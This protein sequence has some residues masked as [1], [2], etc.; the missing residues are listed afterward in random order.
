MSRHFQVDHQPQLNFVMSSTYIET[1]NETDALNFIVKLIK[2]KKLHHPLFDVWKYSSTSDNCK[3]CEEIKTCNQ[4]HNEILKQKV[5]SHIIE[6]CCCSD[7]KLKSLL[8]T[9]NR[10]SSS[11]G[12]VSE[13]RENPANK[14]DLKDFYSQYD[15]ETDNTRYFCHVCVVYGTVA[16][17]KAYTDGG[18]WMNKG[19]SFKSRKSRIKLYM[20]RHIKSRNHIAAL[21]RRQTKIGCTNQPDD[22]VENER[23]PAARNLCMA[24]QYVVDSK[25]SND[26]ITNLA[27]FIKLISPEDQMNPLGNINDPTENFENLILANYDAG[28]IQIRTK[29]NTVN[30]LTRQSRR[31]TISI[32]QVTV[33]Y[34]ITR[35]I[36]VVNYIDDN[37]N[38]TRTC[39]SAG[40]IFSDS[41]EDVLKHISKCCSDFFSLKSIVAICTD[42]A[43]N[44]TGKNMDEVYE[45]MKSDLNYDKRILHLPNL[46]QSIE[47]LLKNNI[48]SC[49]KESLSKIDIIRQIL[50]GKNILSQ[51]LSEFSN[52]HNDLNFFPFEE[53]DEGKYFEYIYHSI[54][55][56]LRNLQ[57]LHIYLPKILNNDRL[58]HLHD[59]AKTV[60]EIVSSYTFISD[61]LFTNAILKE[62]SELDKITSSQELDVKKFIEIKCQLKN[63]LSLLQNKFPLVC[64][65]FFETCK[66]EYVY[67]HDERQYI[68]LVELKNPSHNVN[69]LK[70]EYKKWIQKLLF[71]IDSDISL[72][73]PIEIFDKFFDINDPDDKVY[74][75][76]NIFET[77]NLKFFPCIYGCSGL[78]ICE[79]VMKEINLFINYVNE[80]S[81]ACLLDGK[82]CPKMFIKSV[83]PYRTH[84]LKIRNIYRMVEF[85]LLLNS[86]QSTPKKLI[87]A[88]FDTVQKNFKSKYIDPN[89]SPDLVDIIV[90]LKTNLN[91][92]TLNTE[93]AANIFDKN[94]ESKE[95]DNASVTFKIENVMS[96]KRKSQNIENGRNK[97]IN[98]EEMNYESSFSESEAN[99]H[100][101]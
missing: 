1:D 31:F 36:A 76:Q 80:N 28:K 73:E 97:K 67:E 39:I 87:S 96:S 4:Y 91:Y 57:L 21:K 26:H 25:L 74:S 72:P 22:P 3:H 79:C 9:Y 95:K 20:L 38:L 34:D 45:N 75:F 23:D 14:F 83:K 63:N 29:L 68:S 7:F 86:N 62:F 17:G 92:H 32:N 10:L 65:Q 30:S 18:D 11:V 15:E 51:K 33:P 55:Y 2:E 70:L 48:P 89:E 42:N 101:D 82:F 94:K 90:V 85:Y 44:Y 88:I 99:D 77:F 54:D 16:L 40:R 56:I 64:Q 43:S 13:V 98:L 35:Q 69:D 12:K 5:C 58:E 66:V 53:I 50:N 93:E 47:L 81:S 84:T 59:K 27:S 61:L 52:L 37:G 6:Q 19:V 100:Y 71:K 8:P 60:Y 24:A 49:I 78:K 46:H 41:A